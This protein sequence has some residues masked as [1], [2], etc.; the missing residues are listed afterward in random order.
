MTLPL[1]HSRYS[2]FTLQ[3]QQRLELAANALP[4][5]L[6]ADFRNRVHRYLRTPMGRGLVSD[7]GL[8]IAIG[9]AQREFAEK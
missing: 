1:P 2:H 6:R 9:A 3:Q 5:E 8:A 4:A 7:S